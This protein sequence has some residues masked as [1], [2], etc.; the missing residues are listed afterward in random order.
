MDV[1]AVRPA[2]VLPNV[3]VEETG[4]AP[5]AVE[6]AAVALVRFANG[7]VG[8]KELG[9]FDD[10]VA[11]VGAGAL[12][13]PGVADDVAVGEAVVGAGNCVHEASRF[14]GSV[15]GPPAR[16]VAMGF[17]VEAVFGNGPVKGGAATG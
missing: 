13:A 4:L 8:N 15:V 16:E 5:K 17:V 3:S 12:M 1:G 6:G 10:V 7:L 9:T 2:G 11:A 14:M